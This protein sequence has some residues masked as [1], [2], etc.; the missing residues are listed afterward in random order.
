[1]RATRH[2]FLFRRICCLFAAAGL[3]FHQALADE[4][5]VLFGRT[6]AGLVAVR[7]EFTQPLVLPASVFPGIS[8]FATGAVGF[9]STIL[10]EPTNDFFQL[11]TAADF[12]LILLAKDPGMEIW[13]DTGTGFMAV[14]ESFYVGMPP[15]DTH[16]VWNLVTNKPGIAYSLT[17]KLHDLNAV[18]PDSAPFQ[19]SF[20]SAPTPDAGS[21]GLQL[22]QTDPTHADLSWPTNALG[23]SL[24]TTTSL[25]TTNWMPLT[26]PPAVSGTNFILTIPIT[27]GQ[28]FFRLRSS[29]GT[30]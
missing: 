24:E 8:G 18:Y 7:V 10:D 15:F 22:R 29:S 9:H 20:T 5:D 17:F 27:P 3:T 2:R 11:S 26:N 23:W 28:G 25:T 12:R 1:M 14:G 30:Q 4:Q 21:F 13:N 19:L 16:P 6:A